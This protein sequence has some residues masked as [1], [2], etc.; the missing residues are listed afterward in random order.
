M[1]IR[2][3]ARSRFSKPPRGCRSERFRSH[4]QLANIPSRG[5]KVIP[6]ALEPWW[7]TESG[8]VF[9]VAASNCR[10]QEKGDREGAHMHACTGSSPSKKGAIM[11]RQLPEADAKRGTQWMINSVC[12]TLQPLQTQHQTSSRVASKVSATITLFISISSG[13]VLVL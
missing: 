12:P 9:A 8:A 10:R 2:P 13:C 4:F 1:K 3:F 5:G 6:R 11:L 7:H